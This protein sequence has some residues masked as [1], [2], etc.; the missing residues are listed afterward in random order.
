MVIEEL[1]FFLFCG[2][3]GVFK[4]KKLML[5]G[6]RGNVFNGFVVV[7]FFW[8]VWLMFLY[9]DVSS[10]ILCGLFFRFLVL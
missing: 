5:V 6:F 10:L 7:K 8:V 1:L 3:E 9:C 4:K 2:L